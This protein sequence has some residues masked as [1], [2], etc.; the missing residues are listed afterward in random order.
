MCGNFLRIKFI[1]LFEKNLT[2]YK[3]FPEFTDNPH[4]RIRIF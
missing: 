4:V 1:S 2:T 3:T